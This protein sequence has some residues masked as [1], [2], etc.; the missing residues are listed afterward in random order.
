MPD[1]LLS[2]YD[3]SVF[4]SSLITLNPLLQ[5]HRRIVGVHAKAVDHL[6]GH[7]LGFILMCVFSHSGSGFPNKSVYQLLIL[8]LMD[9]DH[10]AYR[11]V[12]SLLHH[13]GT[14][15]YSKKPD[16]ASEQFGRLYNEVAHLSK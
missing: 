13:A 15:R 11:S 4:N 7:R 1:R 14:G 16:S 8:R 12:V 5:S 9:G 2:P 10:A 3:F 6:A